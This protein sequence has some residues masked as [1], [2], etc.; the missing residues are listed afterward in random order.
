MIQV[1]QLSMHFG[2]KTLFD[3]ATF[4]LNPGNRY[5]VTGANGSGKST[6]L[7][8]LS[9]EMHPEQGE[10]RFPSQVKLGFLKQNHF[11]YERVRIL[12]TVLMGKPALW[13]A[14][15]EKEK[16]LLQEAVDEKAGRRLA[17]L[18]MAIA[19]EGGYEAESA[20]AEILSGLGL[21]SPLHNQTMSVLSGGF[22]L[23]VLLAQVL[24][25]G[26]D[27][28]LLDEPNNHLDIHSIAWL[29]NYLAAYPG[30]VVVVSHDHIF[31]NRVSTH[32]LD[33]DYETIRIYKGNYEQFQSA[34]ALERD[35]K[36]V[37]ILRQ[38]K[39]KEELQ[40]FYERFRAQ[41]TKAR[42]AMSRKK[43]LDRMEEVV[44]TRSSRIAPS[45]DFT[46]R[47][48]TGKQVLRVEG[49][50]KKFGNHV[51]LK[52]V[53]LSVARGDRVAV[54]GPNGVG[55][56]TLLK[57]LM[58]ILKQDQGEVE[59]GHEVA[60]GYFAQNHRE[61]IPAG[62][63]PYEW[64]HG[65]APGESVGKI[66]GILGR[67]LFSGDDEVYKKT[68]NLSG[69]EGARLLFSRLILERPNVLVLD[70]PTNHLDLESIEALGE[71]VARFEGTLIFV[72]HDRFFVD[73][74]AT[75]VLELTSEGF[76]SY[77]GTYAEFLRHRGKDHL[78]RENFTKK[79]QGP[80]REEQ[81]GATPK[82]IDSQERRNLKKEQSRLEKSIPKREE[83][84]SELESRLL[85]TDEKLAEA[86]I[87]ER[88]REAE[89][90]EVLSQKKEMKK[91]LEEEMARWEV[92]HARVEELGRMIAEMDG[93]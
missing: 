44:I 24:F 27:L 40:A 79:R 5:G 17:E 10:I 68:E 48:P 59:W 86:G 62:T 52:N 92:D 20:A 63:T 31:L 32:I 83:R 30:M 54:I 35:Q 39:K 36:D 7:K 70:E 2:E 71:A 28:L 33:I 42:Q 55:K 66:R 18:E 89:L 81:P 37:E 88:G 64:L 12:D 65:M 82:K 4:L 67:M 23:R 80:E 90:R 47:R 41:A 29:E 22:K 76:E 53:A 8:I 78:D 21:A 50:C 87:Y 72:S 15:Q 38:E 11:E 61:Q 57:I 14:M 58:D 6:L 91:A 9:G 49:L 74:A 34:K 84:I 77:R 43:Q 46:Q 73:R 51:V 85:Q 75:A 25:G 26:P 3:E 13:E 93:E 69:G 56:S 19:H 45:F 16:L 60:L 1:N